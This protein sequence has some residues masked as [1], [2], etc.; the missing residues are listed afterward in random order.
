VVEIADHTARFQATAGER[1]LFSLRGTHRDITFNDAG[2]EITLVDAACR[3]VQQSTH[4]V[5]C[6]RAAIALTSIDLADRA[7]YASFGGVPGRFNL[8]GGTGTDEI[9]YSAGGGDTVL[10]SLDGRAND[11]AP[12]SRSNVHPDIENVTFRGGSS[13]SRIVGS[14]RRNHI[15][16]NGRA[17]VL[18]AGGAD[19]LFGR[20]V[21]HGGTGR[22]TLYAHGTGR[23]YGD[24]GDDRISNAFGT[25]G[26]TRGAARFFGGPGR[27]RIDAANFDYVS[28]LEEEG[29]HLAPSRDWVDCG[30]GQDAATVDSRDVVAGGCERTNRL[31]AD[32][33]PSASVQR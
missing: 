6:P 11:G 15:H 21:F 2:A 10:L 7:D 33:G 4:R 22:D 31:T 19:V 17:T 18:G 30:S 5:S 3:G 25:E 9:G 20:G 12:S 29:P 28:G 26:V 13:R 8:R 1:N 24:E 16:S 14:G 27:D 32:D 23:Y